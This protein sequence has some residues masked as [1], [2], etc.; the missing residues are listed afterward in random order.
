VAKKKQSTI[1]GSEILIFPRVS[2]CGVDDQD[3]RLR[4]SL[5]GI[6]VTPDG[7]I[8]DADMEEVAAVNDVAE[9]E[10][11]A[12]YARLHTRR[13]QPIPV[14]EFDRID[15]VMRLCEEL[16][17]A[18]VAMELERA[19]RIGHH[20]PAEFIS[21]L[22]QLREEGAALN[23]PDG[24]EFVRGVEHA[25]DYFYSQVADR[26]FLAINQLALEAR[27]LSQ[28]GKITKAFDSRVVGMVERIRRRQIE[29][30]LSDG[31]GNQSGVE[32]FDRSSF[33]AQVDAA[34]L[35]AKQDGAPS[36]DIT[37]KRI[38]ADLNIGDIAKGTGADVL[39]KRLIVCG[40]TQSWAQ[41]LDSV[42]EKAAKP[43]R[44]SKKS[45]S[46]FR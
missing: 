43:K 37:Q 19:K 14:D 45:K 13:V 6:R 42:I 9:R 35:K 25:A 15:G 12:L 1:D 23:R 44:K 31:R 10:H 5:M 21:A 17:R 8:Q 22:N 24:E 16:T 3:H 20:A 29:S 7:A 11:K 2:I 38:A 36:R 40:V 30:H 18:F 32:M 27:V 4:E 41:Y 39:R 26:I 33:L 46:D 34:I 28:A